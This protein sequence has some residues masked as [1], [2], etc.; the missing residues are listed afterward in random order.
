MDIETTDGPA[1]LKHYTRLDRLLAILESGSLRLAGPE[2]WE[3][4]NDRASLAAYCRKKNAGKA[5][6]L[7]FTQDE[8][9]VHH[10]Y[11]YA[12]GSSGCRIEFK[13]RAFLEKIGSIPGLVGKK[14]IYVRRPFDFLSTPPDDLPFLKR[15]PYQCEKEFRLVWAGTKKEEAPEVPIAGLIAG[16]TFS[17]WTHEKTVNTLR[18]L[19]RR[20]YKISRVVRSTILEFP[21]WINKMKDVT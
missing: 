14:L 17:P 11:C 20:Q 4:R 3:D 21:E 16:I 13:T 1:F 12:N 18:E 7:C 10:W 5:R 9:T 15:F 2:N 19:F 8:E 6:V